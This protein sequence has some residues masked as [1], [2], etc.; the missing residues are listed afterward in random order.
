MRRHGDGVAARV[1]KPVPSVH[2][3][4]RIGAAAAL[5]SA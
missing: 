5:R 3:R 2:G 4:L 1:C